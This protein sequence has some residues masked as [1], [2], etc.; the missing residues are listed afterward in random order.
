M[1]FPKLKIWVDSCHEQIKQVGFIYSF[2]GRKRRLRNFRSTDRGVIGEEVRSGF[3]AII[4]S[5]SSD[6]LLLG[7]IDADNEILEKG[8][9]IQIFGLV[10]DSIIA[11]VR[12]D[13]VD[14]YNEIIDRNIQKSRGNWDPA[15]GYLSIPGAPIGIDSDSEEG[16][17]RD[18]GCGK[19]AK[20]FPFLACVDDFDDRATSTCIEV[21]EA[22]KSGNT[23]DLD[24]EDKVVKAAL[25]YPQ[26]ILEVLQ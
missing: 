12:E 21:L 4:Q 8:L 22:M 2:F 26:E 10:H 13:L 16:G 19:L 24:Y 5:A 1:K 11:L 15:N 18:Y 9:D 7:V 23:K 6:S 3:N 14:E 25:K 17:S 20:M